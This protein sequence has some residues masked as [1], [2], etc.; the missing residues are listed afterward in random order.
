M[1]KTFCIL[2]IIS[3]FGNLSVQ[4]QN[5]ETFLDRFKEKP[6]K[7]SGGLSVNQILYGINGIEARRDP[8]TYFLS[9][10]I[11]LSVYGWNIPFSGT[12][13]NQEFQY[14]TMKLMPYNTELHRIINRSKYTSG[15]G[16]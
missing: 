4:A 15:I 2:L 9:G 5:V 14:Q 3:F 16:Q 6:F 12:Y 10:N 8:Y 11:N 7:L 1:K 13:S